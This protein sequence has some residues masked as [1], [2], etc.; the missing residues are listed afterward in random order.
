MNGEV[1]S[2]LKDE[3]VRFSEV[4]SRNLRL[5]CH[6]PGGRDGG[7]VCFMNEAGL[8]IQVGY[9]ETGMQQEKPPLAGTF[10]VVVDDLGQGLRPHQWEVTRALSGRW[11]DQKD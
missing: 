5:P 2:S 7:E 9:E 1:E 11:F 4:R 3:M 10:T 6:L 8:V